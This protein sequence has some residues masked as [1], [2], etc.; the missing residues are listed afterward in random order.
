MNAVDGS[1]PI[2]KTPMEQVDELKY[3]LATAPG[4]WDSDTNIRRYLLP[5][6][7]HISCVL[8]NSLFHIT[9]TDIVRSLVFR[10]QAFGRPVKNIKKFEEGVFSDLRNLKPGL[11]ASLEEPKSEFLEML[12]KNNCIR[13]QK[14]QKVFYWF[15]VPHDR[16]FLDALERDLKREKIGIEPTTVAVTEPAISFSF[17]ST[18]SL[19][20]QFTKG[21]S[22]ESS[23]PSSPQ[24][25]S[26]VYEP[27]IQ[28]LAPAMMGPQIKSDEQVNVLYSLGEDSV[29]NVASTQS[30]L[31]TFAL[32]QSIPQCDHALGKGHLFS[33]PDLGYCSMDELQKTSF[34]INPA[35]E[36]IVT[37]GWNPSSIDEQY[38]EGCRPTHD[39]ADS[40]LSNVS[41]AIVPSSN[42]NNNSTASA[43]A[44]L[45]GMFS[46]FEGSPTYKQRRRRASSCAGV[47]VSQNSPPMRSNTAPYP[48]KTYTCPLPTCGRLFKRLE[49]LK[50]HVR[51]HT[52]ERPYSCSICGKRF[53]RSDNL[54]QH[55]KTHERGMANSPPPSDDGTNGSD[56][57]FDDNVVS[58]CFNF[59]APDMAV[60]TCVPDGYAV[61]APEPTNYS[62]FSLPSNYMETSAS[63]GIIV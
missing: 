34:E 32:F 47:N 9:G 29:G 16:L 55:K 58:E 38:V 31:S 44:N 52:M 42:Y 25:P 56:L 19:Y 60:T 24:L 48:V 46:I 2:N 33:S 37:A 17:D 39:Q 6:G 54:A 11:D 57:G 35:S 40:Q 50:R 13:T 43:A 62:V 7:E 28:A 27:A 8:W 23:A 51:T 59:E 49:H 21:M 30:P 22:R 5:T 41:Q 20:D 15:S 63:N 10:F 45:F 3:W 14:K 61:L 36:Y 26:L 1:A 4:N 53:S 12:Y 18:Q